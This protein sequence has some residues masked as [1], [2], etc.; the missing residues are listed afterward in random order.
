HRFDVP[1]FDVGENSA[2]R[3]RRHQVVVFGRQD[4][5]GTSDRPEIDATA[6]Q[7]KL[8]SHQFVALVTA[9]D[10]FAKG[11][12]CNGNVVVDPALHCEKVGNKPRIVELF[13]EGHL[14]LEEILHRLHEQETGLEKES[15]AIA[16]SIDERIDVEILAVGPEIQERFSAA[17]I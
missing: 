14:L 3:R 9:L 2:S 12:T 8:P 1:G 7:M 10:E 17:E 15:W 13:V 4:E 6:A 5:Q 11:F 16:M